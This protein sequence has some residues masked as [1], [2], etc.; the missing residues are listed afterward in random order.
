MKKCHNFQLIGSVVLLL[1]DSLPIQLRIVVW[2]SL[3]TIA[4]PLFYIVAAEKERLK[5]C[6]MPSVSFCTNNNV[7]PLVI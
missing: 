3:S 6:R 7:H 1:A 2:K 5:L 4:P